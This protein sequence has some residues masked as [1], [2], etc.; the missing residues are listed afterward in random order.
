VNADKAFAALTPQASITHL[1]L[2]PEPSPEAID[3]FISKWSHSGGHER[4]S[5]QYFVLDLCDLL[6][7]EK[8][9]APLPENELNGYTFE[10]RVDRKKPDG[11]TTP[12]WIDLY[13]TGHFVLETKQGVNARRDKSNPDQP[14]LPALEK[15][16]A[17][18]AGH[19]QRG[20]ATWDK[21]LERAH[22]QAER[23]IH[24][25]PLGEGRPPFLIVCDVG[26]CFDLYA[27]FSGTGGQYEAF[28]DPRSRRILL[29]DL[30]KQEVRELF[31]KIWHDPRSLDPSKHAA[32][33]T[34]EVAKALAD[35][36]KSLEKDGHDPQI[37]AG[38]L[39]RCL[40]TMFAEDIGLLTKDSFANLLRIAKGRP[41]GFP[42]MLHSLWKDM[43]TGSD[44]SLVLQE[45]IPYFNGGLFKD[46]TALPLRPD[47]I[48]Y[49]LHA[50]KQ[51][52]AA[53]EPAI[54]GTLLERALDPRERHKLGAHYTPR[55]YVERLVRPTLIE[56]LREKW[57]AVKLSAAQLDD[58]G[59]TKEA[60]AA[61]ETFHHELTAIR[62]L[63]PACG[64]GNFL[65][66]ALELLK[67]LEAEVLDLF[68]SLGG[69]RSFESD[70][71]SLRPKNFLGIEL[72]PRA[73]AIAQLVLWIGY[74]QWHKRT[75]GRADTN[76][77]PLLPKENTIECRDAVLDYDEKIP[78]RDATGEIVTIWD[79]TSV[80]R[81]PVTEREVPDETA[82]TE[83]SDYVNPKRAEWPQADFI[84]GNPP[85]I[86]VRK[87]IP[88]LGEGY[89][90]AL[91]KAF[92][93]LPDTSDFVIYWWRTAASALR[94]G[95][96]KRFGFITTNSIT[97]EYSRAAIE[98]DLGANS[99]PIHLLFA[100]PDHPWVDSADGAAVRVAMLVGSLDDSPGLL[101][102]VENED[103]D[104]VDG[105]VPFIAT[106]ERRC[107]IDSRLQPAI[108]LNKVRS[109]LAN[110][111]MCFQGVV[112]AGDGFKLE[113]LGRF[114]N[115]STK[116]D[117][118]SLV[119][120]YLIGKDLV[121]SPKLR[122]IIDCFGMREDEVRGQHP[123]IFQHLFTNVK[124]E[125]DQNRRQ[126]YKEKW[127]L[128]AEPRPAMR[129]ALAGLKR[130]IGTPY[131]S[132]F[133]PFVF[134]DG[135]IVPDAMVYAIAS[136]DA[137]DLGVLSSTVHTT[138]AS[139][140]GGR[141][142]V[143]NDSRYTSNGTFLPYPFPALE[144]GP[145]KARIRDLGERL[146]SHRKARQTAHPELTLTG[147][148][149]VVEKLRAGEM[150]ND[151][152][153]KVHDLGLVT[154]LKQL[155]D[156]LDAA[157]LEAY[158]WQ[159]LGRDGSPSGPAGDSSLP[160]S[161]SAPVN[162][163]P[164]A[165][166][167]GGRPLPFADRLARGGEAAQAL[168]QE[169]LSRLVSLNH[170]RTAEEKRGLI[171]WLRPDY[172]APT[173]PSVEQT[174]I[175]LPAA[176]NGE[177]AA[178]VKEATAARAWPES[179]PAQMTAILNLLPATGPDATVLAGH[180]GKRTK[181]RVAKVAEILE[182]LKTLGRL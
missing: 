52:W 119:R 46:T 29:K 167:S 160:D 84:V 19:G 180:F 153:K 99:K 74:F 77:R 133:R 182:T 107:T 50:A 9:A 60:R 171:R 87:M 33:V 54:F 30:H 72:N 123:E 103:V 149:N 106:R 81:H 142:G 113:T 178:V 27:E 85:Y 67:R 150:L 177:K 104:A 34:R 128:F 105:E 121:Q 92:S 164:S 137:A 64:S 24:L 18:S 165:G 15:P 39:Q 136:G 31:R 28:P 152:D 156:E 162:G 45:R 78:R 141:M 12:N 26:H 127:W 158:V 94:N 65:Y 108:G 73:A 154:L 102:E 143:G 95:Q 96:T 61:V 70:Q 13:K 88:A 125:R 44:F 110:E 51:D 148:Y 35:L 172:Q 36:A 69:N 166:P 58:K 139:A 42:V 112:P 2:M 48:V 151:K 37:T 10:R 126:S 176:A 21:A 11:S 132:K 25:L 83:V 22:K 155:H 91:R 80:V 57:E 131:T 20:S 90:Q 71:W 1:S 181:Q 168:E 93:D 147:M 146:D 97:Q 8:P 23:Y 32:A 63:D 130:Y 75:T 43:D 124:P 174:A 134:I 3:S 62:V 140:A 173:A 66:V 68:E 59:K 138:W 144:E 76:D 161:I 98:S 38:F 41:E 122:F 159:D 117:G 56:P 100:V 135:A 179:L 82:R 79:G 145:L 163:A 86:G 5:G 115:N 116:S 89:V 49:L 175:N 114:A 16:A 157:V 170:E 169:L 6:R 109:L 55:S 53:V 17:K 40:F 118:Q 4:G 47:Q 111:A 101:V 14:L 7:L 120:P 129:K